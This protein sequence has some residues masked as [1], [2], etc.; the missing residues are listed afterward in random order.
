M[1]SWDQSVT[2]ASD[3]NSIWNLTPSL[4][5]QQ[6]GMPVMQPSSF[7]SKKK[8]KIKKKNN[9]IKELNFSFPFIFLSLNYDSNDA[10]GS[11]TSKSFLPQTNWQKTEY[12]VK[13]QVCIFSPHFRE[14]STKR[15]ISW[16][17][18]SIVYLE[19]MSWRAQLGDTNWTFIFF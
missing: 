2:R 14:Q 11:L 10:S 12:W 17:E 9:K 3:S 5:S 8:K 13:G 19:E 7:T 6:T 18:Y 15:V 16:P 1:F 4:T